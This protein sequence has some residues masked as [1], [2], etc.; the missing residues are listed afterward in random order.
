MSELSD[1]IFCSLCRGRSLDDPEE[2]FTHEKCAEMM[3][4]DDQLSV[5]IY[6]AYHRQGDDLTR[7]SVDTDGVL[8]PYKSF[9]NL[10]WHLGGVSKNIKLIST[11]IKNADP[12]ELTLVSDNHYIRLTGPRE[13]IFPLLSN[14]LCT[15]DP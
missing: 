2:E 13:L 3:T 12:R 6:L 7:F 14:K 4:E 9:E 8:D 5:R 11:A 1:L 10:A 15:F